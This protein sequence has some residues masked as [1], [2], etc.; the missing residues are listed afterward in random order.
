MIC[1]IDK[2]KETELFQANRVCSCHHNDDNIDIL[3]CK[4]E[5]M[6]INSSHI[7]FTDNIQDTRIKSHLISI[8]IEKDTKYFISRSWYDIIYNIQ[9][10]HSGS[11]NLQKIKIGKGDKLKDVNIEDA[12]TI[13]KLQPD[14]IFILSD[15]DA[16]ITYNSI[17]FSNHTESIKRFMSLFRL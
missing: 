10:T 3:Y 12:F 15:K 6:N 16:N 7:Q 8:D 13:D 11:F 1:C 17:T 9:A 5:Y 2:E 4:D 14:D